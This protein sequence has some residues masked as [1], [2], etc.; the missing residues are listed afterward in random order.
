TNKLMPC[1]INLVIEYII[2]CEDKNN[3]AIQHIYLYGYIII[4]GL[5]ASPRNK[6]AYI[7]A[8]NSI[9]IIIRRNRHRITYSFFDFLIGRIFYYLYHSFMNTTN[10]R[11]VIYSIYRIIIEMMANYYNIF[12]NELANI[13]SSTK[14]LNHDINSILKTTDDLYESLSFKNETNQR[15]FKH[16]EKYIEWMCLLRKNYTYVIVVPPT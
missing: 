8:I 10:D 16:F 2:F 3:I 12:R 14:L 9:F 11:L 15:D 13:L 5:Y 6:M 4:H 7:K 1:F